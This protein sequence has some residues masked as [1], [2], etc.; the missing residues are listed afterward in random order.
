MDE[1]RKVYGA[2]LFRQFLV[3]NSVLLPF[4]RYL[5]LSLSDFYWVNMAFTV[6]TTVSE[7]PTGIFSDR[8]GARKS[9][10]LSSIAYFLGSLFLL[11]YPNLI[12]LVI[13]QALLGL[14]ISFLSGS[15]NAILLKYIKNFNGRKLF[16]KR[17]SGLL[18]S[19]ISALLIIKE[20]YKVMIFIQVVAGM[21]MFLVAISLKKT[22]NH[23]EITDKGGGECTFDILKNIIKNPDIKRLFLLLNFSSL[24]FFI[25]MNS[26]QPII[27]N[28][29]L[30]K[31]YFGL[32]VTI[33]SV[34]QVLAMYFSYK[35][36]LISLKLSILFLFLPLGLVFVKS[37]WIL[38]LIFLI[39]LS[40]R[41]IFF[42][43]YDEYLHLCPKEKIA[44]YSS[45]FNLSANIFLTI[46]S[47]LMSYF[48][49]F[50][51]LEHSL[52]FTA[53]AATLIFSVMYIFCSFRD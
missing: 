2:H 52:I 19:M 45:V 1:V 49:E 13:S 34:A 51:S 35:L 7:L 53:A 9:I 33:L 31:S 37:P 25:L 4:V 6:T 16:W 50:H 24:L 44:T 36:R 26:S 21:G 29:G 11:L 23:V 28:S 41:A 46:Q 22:S 30:E 18:A 38:S 39:S 27:E 17:L 40:S 43:H 32:A 42:N 5:K 14:S 47:G 48:T 8:F 12:S 3:L 15:D 20:Q 10:I